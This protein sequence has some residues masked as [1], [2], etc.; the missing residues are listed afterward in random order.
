MDP[1]ENDH[2]PTRNTPSQAP[3][4]RSAHDES[5]EEGSILRPLRTFKDDVATALGKQGGGVLG[6]VASE[7]R[8]REG[9]QVLSEREQKLQGQIEKEGA[10]IRTLT[11]QIEAGKYREGEV[12]GVQSPELKEAQARPSV[13]QQIKRE[14]TPP[15]GIPPHL[16]LPKEEPERAG[17]RPH[18]PVDRAGQLAE[19]RAAEKRLAE[20]EAAL[21]DTKRKRAVA[22]PTR[23]RPEP[24]QP[25]VKRSTLVIVGI[26][27]TLILV[28][29]G[30]EAQQYRKLCAIYP[31]S[32]GIAD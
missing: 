24:K 15:P 14:Y 8:R 25:R 22:T 18:P 3:Q 1:K 32:G 5:R 19:L 31:A 16:V 23:L 11:A 20:A 27:A 29:S 13:G 9:R 28:A 10:K 6:V 4:G 21:E 12:P 30:S 7:A 26:S 17:E 2:I